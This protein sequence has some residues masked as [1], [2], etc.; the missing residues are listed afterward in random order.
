MTDEK[1]MAGEVVR[2]AAKF[3]ARDIGPAAALVDH[4]AP[5]FPAEVFAKGVAAGFD[6]FVLPED[7]GGYGFSRDQLCGLLSTLAQT[8]AG[9]AMV[10]G[11]HAAALNAIYGVC[12]HES[13]SLLEKVLFSGRA[14]GVTLGEPVSVE[15]PDTELTAEQVSDGGVRLDGDGGLAFNASPDGFIV[16]F[17]GSRDAG[18][19]A[20]LVDCAE[21]EE[22]LGAAEAVLGLRA[23]TI[24]R[25][26]F[27]RIAIQPE[28]VIAQGDNAAEFHKMLLGQLCLTVS[29]ACAGVM[30]GAH[31]QALK[32]AS[33]RYQGGKM[34][35]DHSHLQGI[36]GSMSAKA[37]TA[38]GAVT[39]AACEPVDLLSALRVKAMVSDWAVQACADAVQILGG[40][41]YMRDYGL[42]K[43]MRDAA[44]LSLL[45]VSNARAELL[46]TRIE[47][48]AL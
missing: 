12:G 27:H 37:G 6:R 35:V 2:T 41:G 36:L 43:A 23:M 38:L 34:I 5:V 47:K 11:V 1:Q 46:I 40:Y 17:A 21:A 28:N 7:A 33:E 16:A 26:E 9:H 13:R 44:V 42:E 31:R 25:L 20:V 45:P 24:A 10:F 18:Y 15:E 14:V 3:A 32:Y 19:Q 4:A 30:H 22:S 29:A 8:C 39:H 48:E